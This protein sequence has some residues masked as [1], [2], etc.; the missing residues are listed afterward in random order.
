[1]RSRNWLSS[2]GAKANMKRERNNADKGKV[3]KSQIKTVRGY[4]SLGVHWI[5]IEVLTVL[6]ICRMRRPWPSSA[7]S[8]CRPSCRLPRPLR[9]WYS[10]DAVE[11]TR[12]A[13]VFS[14]QSAWARYQ[15]AQE[16]A[17]W[18]LPWRERIEMLLLECKRAGW[19]CMLN[20][21]LAFKRTVLESQFTVYWRYWFPTH[22]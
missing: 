8:A 14:V 10:R 13:N 1:M 16:G 22:T 17:C 5:W 3:A 7:R 20:A 18:L 15:Q 12:F 4:L 9:M 21:W 11:N 6:L 2:Q 19:W